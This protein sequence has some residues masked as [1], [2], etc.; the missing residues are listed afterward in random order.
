MTILTMQR[1]R[2]A[3]AASISAVLAACAGSPGAFPPNVPVVGAPAPQPQL[4]APQP[5]PSSAPA[6]SEYSS[7]GN[8]TIDKWRDEF[9]AEVSDQGRQDWAVRAVLEGVEPMERF[10][11][12][13][14]KA[15]SASDVSSQAEF[16]KPIWDY[17]RTAVASSRRVKGAREVSELSLIHI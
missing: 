12:T 17:L 6:A 1:V 5:V 11:S 8:Q 9:A 10:F 15:A 3:A 2:W 13:R 7:S 16:S 4:P 14:I